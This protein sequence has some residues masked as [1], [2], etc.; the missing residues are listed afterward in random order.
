[1][2]SLVFVHG[3]G[4][5]APKNGDHPLAATSRCIGWELFHKRIEWKVVPCNWGDDLGA[6][7]HADGKSLPPLQG[8]LGIA[9]QPD[10]PAGLWEI[11][12][13][14]PTF[15]LRALAGMS[16]S[17][18]GGP[19]PGTRGGPPGGSRPAWIDLQARLAAGIQ[20][21]GALAERLD[22]YDLKDCF[23][24]A[25][26]QVQ[27]DPAVPAAI[28]EP[29]APRAI[30][31]AIVARM[32]RMALEQGIPAPGLVD[33]EAIVSDVEQILRPAQLGAV[34]D[35][36]K[37]VLMGW[38]TSLGERRRITLSVAATPIAGDVIYYQAHGERIR[39]RIRDAISDA[40][41]PV[42]VLAHSLGGVATTE[43]FCQYPALRQ[44]V[45]KFITAGSQPGFFY[46]ID[47]L[48]ILPFG[49][50]LP[51]D[52]PD[53]LN[54]WDPRDFL[55]FLIGPVFTGGRSR[56][57]AKVESGLPFP[58]SHSGYWRQPVT[59]GRVEK[60]LAS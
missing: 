47:A 19:P 20:P 58:A 25:L 37:S 22:R 50:P 32:L 59:W 9:V 56:N 39:A 24:Q 13:D 31:R 60:F 10:D 33:I 55:S 17:G 49:K 42:A 23:G 14:D 45:R 51:D 43:A 28:A 18:A 36:A 40:P 35:W 5:R 21:V 8:K 27:A 52:F 46:E 30:A 57:D 3:I 2:G 15:E 54:F 41:E 26:S 7:L 38:S 44:R 4:V 12:L 34:S 53:W 48:R 1:M 16:T 6:R 29:Q 11:L